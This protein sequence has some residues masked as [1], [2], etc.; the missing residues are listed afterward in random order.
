MRNAKKMAGVQQARP[1]F[2]WGFLAGVA[3]GVAG[4]AAMVV[5]GRLLAPSEPEM[6][7]P[8]V[9][10]AGSADVHGLVD[11]VAGGAVG[12]SFHWTFGALAGGVYGMLAEVWPRVTE[13]NGSAFGIAVNF[14]LHG[15]SLPKL[16]ST[17]KDVE[18][19]GREQEMTGHAVFG[20][21]AE[22]VRK[23]TRCWLESRET[24][25]RRGASERAERYAA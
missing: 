14:A 11:R 21:T 7:P 18:A 25:H 5:A 24:T 4:T 23:H 1:H 19:A 12:P 2:L 15:E 20:M 8:E 22:F 13:G 10:P 16:A 9:L 17:L 3:G 6:V